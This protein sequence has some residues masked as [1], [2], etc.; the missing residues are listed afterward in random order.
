M[1]IC[2]ECGVLSGGGPCDMPIACSALLC[3]ILKPQELGELLTLED[4]TDRMYRHVGKKL[5]LLVV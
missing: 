3:V 4:V 2:C 5:P 1:F